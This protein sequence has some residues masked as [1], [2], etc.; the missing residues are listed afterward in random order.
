MKKV[1]CTFLLCFA[2]L[3]VHGQVNLVPNPSFEEYSE[4]PSVFLITGLDGWSSYRGTPDYYNS[5]AEGDLSTPCNLSGCQNPATGEGYIGLYAFS[6]GTYMDG[7]PFREI[8][9]S[10]LLEPLIV[11]QTY[12]VSFKASTVYGGYFVNNC[13]SDKLGVKFSMTPYSYDY[14]NPQLSATVDNFSHIYSN[15]IIADT[16]NWIGI[17]GSFVADMPYQYVMLGNFFDNEN[18]DTILL[19]EAISVVK[20]YYFIDDICV[21]T[22]SQG[23][24]FASNIVE[25]SKDKLNIY[26][27]PTSEF[28]YIDC[29]NFESTN[30]EIKL[31]TLL[32]NELKVSFSQN[33]NLITINVSDLSSGIYIVKIKSLSGKIISQK[34]TIT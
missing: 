22:D 12:Y 27:N 18:T 25:I 4:C 19:S 10:Q 1:I 15:E 29:Q 14:D 9:G 31:L 28:L 8:V 26:P 7:S 21:T 3:E 2:L 20:S 11:G 33:S 24:D 16:N 13:F 34:V 32:G 17:S 23:C 6:T 5:C 30:T